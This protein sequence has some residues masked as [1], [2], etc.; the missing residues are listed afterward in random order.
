MRVLHL[1]A[2]N[3]Y[4]GVEVLLATLA[5]FRRDCPEME[6]HFCVCFEGRF[7][8]EMRENGIPVEVVGRARTREFWTIWKARRR[9]RDVLI[10][11]RYD[12]VI[13]HGAWNYAIFG[14]VAR[15]A[16]I[17]IV[18][19]L[20][21][22]P[23]QRMLWLERWAHRVAPDLVICNSHY[24]ANGA[25]HFFPGVVKKV[26]YCAVAPRQSG[27]TLP[28]DVT[29]VRAD[30]DTASD[31]TVI[32][33]VSRLDPHKG[34]RVHLEALAKLR[35]IP[36]WVCWQVAGPQRPHEVRYLAELKEFAASSGIRDR[37]HFLGWQP[38]IGKL[39]AAA[40]IY[41][42]PNVGPEPFGITFVEALYDGLPVIATAIGGPLE[43]VEP[44]CGVLV[45]PNDAASL[46]QELQT[47]IQ[48]GPLRKRLGRF[49]PARAEGLCSPRAR[50]AELH[51]TLRRITSGRIAA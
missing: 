5:R 19:W 20:H 32:L 30:L 40:D 2:G 38:D 9:F 51:E 10:R 36:G 39:F 35:D 6:P 41:C 28:V 15:A 11:D 42:Q 1:T 47:L 27:S 21:D 13:C 16:D 34:H 31:A 24:T 50:L 3:L 26:I 45:A 17:P 49:G 22:P 25:P 44:N 48:N 18:F 14:P 29:A 33:Q 4:G 23:P 46:A 7:S 37:V 8:S 12:V 43:I